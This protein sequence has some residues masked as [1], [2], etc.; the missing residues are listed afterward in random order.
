MKK[1]VWL[2]LAVFVL[3]AVG[4]GGGDE[5][6]ASRKDPANDPVAKDE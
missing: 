3:A 1:V 5:G 6:D 4:C 2:L